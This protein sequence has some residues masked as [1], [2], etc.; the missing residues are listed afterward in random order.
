VDTFL[1]VGAEPLESAR[2]FCAARGLEPPAEAPPI[3]TGQA[4]MFRV[5][6]PGTIRR[7][8]VIP[9]IGSRRRHIRKYAEGR[10]GEES[11]F[12][13]R[14]P[15]EKLRLRVHNL[16][17]FIQMGEGVDEETWEHHRRRGDYSDWMRR[18]VKDSDL[19]EEVA[20]IE[21][22]DLPF[23]TARERVHAAVERRYTAPG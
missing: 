14:G 15:E 6:Q 4:L 2:S 10:L 1:I 12:Y 11:V 21:A 18:C 17:L 20:S 13:Y 22:S 3:A 7:V 8:E 5:D 9:G 16:V 23:D 19:A